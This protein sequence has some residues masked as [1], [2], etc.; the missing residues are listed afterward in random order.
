VTIERAK[1]MRV[2]FTAL[3][4]ASVVQDKPP[5]DLM[6]G[7]VVAPCP[8]PAATNLRLAQGLAQ[9]RTGYD[10]LGAAAATRVTGLRQVI[11]DDG[12]THLVRTNKTTIDVLAAGV[13][14]SIQGAIANF[15]GG[16]LDFFQ[17]TTAPR[18]GA[19]TPKNLLIGTNNVD[20]LFKWTGTGNITAVA[21]T[22]PT[23][24]KVLTTFNNRLF[25]FNIVSG[26]N[27]YT[28][29]AK[30][31]IVGDSE[32]WTGLG[33]GETDLN[34]DAYPIT[35]AAVINARLCVFKGDEK[36][37]SL[38]VG[39]PTG[40]PLSPVRWD[41]ANAGSGVGILVPRSLVLL[42]PNLAFF[43]GHD[44]FYIY[45]GARG[46]M[47]I[48]DGI[49][50]SLMPRIN[51]DA[52]EAG[53]AW[54]RPRTYEIYVA[55]P[56]GGATTANETWVVNIR[57]RRLYGPMSYSHAFTAA[58]PYVQTGSLTWDT[59]P[60][61]SWD[62][63]PFTSWDAI[64]GAAGAS[65]LVYGASTGATYIDDDSDFDDDGAGIGGSWLSPAVTPANMAAGTPPQARAL[66]ADDHLVLREVMIRYKALGEWTPLVEVTR[67]G[68]ATWET[69]ST[70]ETIGDSSGRI[71]TK[72]F[73]CEMPGTWFQ[74][75]VSSATSGRIAL[76]SVETE[77]TYAGTD[78][79]G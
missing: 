6:K 35:A 30:W 46:L 33:S 53:F 51:Y 19:V 4:E 62:A 75:R 56:V 17:F 67:D 21:G 40:N 5:E 50:E 41:S 23:T 49:S 77:Y 57:E 25:A 32:N 71:L 72:T 34:E 73:D 47:P 16:D 1:A 26:G 13:W 58:S 61:G 24:A 43:V 79:V 42:N 15:A 8:S 38:V 18:A 7:P 28:T 3:G 59:L 52:L 70:G 54:Y 48:S 10:A 44:G 45:D 69:V 55:L 66:S 36:G 60:G 9:S 31:T 63:L 64:G 37:G 2:L 22:P 14:T 78:R 65:A 68:Q 20:P 12:T 76:H 39:T 74:F 29:R 27:R 11:F